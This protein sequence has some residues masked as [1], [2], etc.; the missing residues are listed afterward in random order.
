MT[1][2]FAYR[3]DILEALEGHG[4][5][6]RETTSPAL[7]RDYVNDLYR[8][9]IRRLKARLLRGE[10]PQAEYFGR[11]VLLRRRYPVLSVA[12]SQWTV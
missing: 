6:P 5:R 7:V 9:E 8:Y 10:F 2:R 1:A 12:V 3:P 4:V 11:V